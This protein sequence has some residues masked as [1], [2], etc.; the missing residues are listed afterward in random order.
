MTG[1]DRVAPDIDMD[2]IIQSFIREQLSMNPAQ[3]YMSTQGSLESGTMAPTSSMPQPMSVSAV[4]VGGLDVGY[5][6]QPWSMMDYHV[7]GLAEEILF[8]FNGAGV[9]GMW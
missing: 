6:D 1:D 8:G 5:M 2:A 7:G 3:T 4:P 9:D